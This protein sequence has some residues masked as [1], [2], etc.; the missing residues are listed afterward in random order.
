MCISMRPDVLCIRTRT[1][2]TGIMIAAGGRGRSA[3]W[4][5]RIPEYISYAGCSAL[6]PNQQKI[7]IFLHPNGG[8]RGITYE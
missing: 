2:D 7:F 3:Y 5:I 6:P 4:H 8:R 1:K